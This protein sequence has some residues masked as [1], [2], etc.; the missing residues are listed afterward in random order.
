MIYIKNRSSQQT[1]AYKITQPTPSDAPTVSNLKDHTS[2]SSNSHA[3]IYK[4]SPIR[5]TITQKKKNSKY[6]ALRYNQS[7]VVVTS[8]MWK[9]TLATVGC[10]W[11]LYSALTPSS[12]TSHTDTLPPTNCTYAYSW[13]WTTAP[14]RP[15]TPR[16]GRESILCKR[17]NMVTHWSVG[18]RRAWLLLLS[19]IEKRS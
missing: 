4:K 19:E 2:Y 10:Q 9:P 18:V 3:D 5:K 1:L 11:S 8:K 7:Q 15:Y 12:L 14:V 13:D 16:T 17:F 6:F